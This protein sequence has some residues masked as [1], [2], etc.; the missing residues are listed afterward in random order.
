MAE[1]V[2]GLGIRSCIWIFLE[3]LVLFFSEQLRH[4]FAHLEDC[5]MLRDMLTLNEEPL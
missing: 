2:K 5:G 1:V 3:P 4:I